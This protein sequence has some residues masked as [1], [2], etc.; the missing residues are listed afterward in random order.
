[1]ALRLQ[2]YELKLKHIP[3][4]DMLIADFLSRAFLKQ[5]RNQSQI[6]NDLEHINQIEYVNVSRSTENLLK[7]ATKADVNLMELMLMVQHGWP[8]IKSDVPCAIQSYFSFRD[9]ITMQDGILYKGQQIIVPQSMQALLLKKAHNSHQGAEACIRRAKDSLFWHGMSAQ[10][11]DLVSSCEIC[12]SLRP[13]QQKESMMTWE[14]PTERWQIVAQDLFTIQ[15][16]DYLITVDYFSDFWE[17]DEL[18]DTTSPTI[19]ECTKRHFSRHGIPR[20]VVTDNG[21]QLVSKEYQDFA[22]SWEFEHVTSSPLH[23]QSNGK[24]ESAV[25]IAKNLIKKARKENKD[26][27]LAIL[28]WRNTPDTEGNS[29]VQK[30]MSRRTRTLL[31]TNEQL[32]QPQITKNV[33]DNIITRRRKA[34]FYY[35]KKSKDLPELNIGETVRIQPDQNHPEWRKARCILKAG[36]RSYVVETEKG[37]KYRRNRKFLR[38]GNETYEKKATESL[39]HPL[40]I[41]PMLQPVITDKQPSTDVTTPSNP[42]TVI[43]N[44]QIQVTKESKST[45]TRS[46]IKLPERYRDFVLNK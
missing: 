13:K 31:Q 36:P 16:R 19:I 3:G 5:K 43:P 14:I 37:M 39:I 10:I 20:K 22:K 6:L 8:E 11:K 45:R 15:Q 28:D 41:E 27:Y 30:L 33:V 40:D 12:N 9:E 26:I 44:T 23:S 21:P 2:R 38:T 17:V 46:N 1:M 24:A 34:K 42:E 35:D 25:K 29:P 32:L 18:E 7:N 4:K